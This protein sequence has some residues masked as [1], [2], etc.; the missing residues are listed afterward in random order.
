[1]INNYNWNV[2]NINAIKS[3]GN[4]VSVASDLTNYFFLKYAAV[5]VMLNFLRAVLCLYIVHT[6][7]STEFEWW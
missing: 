1:M 6:A 7:H 3:K 2:L 4:Y 5:L